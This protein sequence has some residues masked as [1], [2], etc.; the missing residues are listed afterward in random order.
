[1]LKRKIQLVIIWKIQWEY[2]DLS[3][4]SFGYRGFVVFVREFIVVVGGI[5]RKGEGKDVERLVLL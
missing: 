2:L 3:Y 5:G 1:M 4:V